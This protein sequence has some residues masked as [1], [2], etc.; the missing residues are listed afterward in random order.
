M[1]HFYKHIL[2]GI[3]FWLILSQSLSLFNSSSAAASSRAVEVAEEDDAELQ[4]NALQNEEEG[5]EGHYF[6]ELL[7][8]VKREIADVETGRSSSGIF[9]TTLAFT[10]PLFSFTLPDRAAAGKDYTKQAAWSLIGLAAIGGIAIFPYVWTARGS[11][12][13]DKNIL[14]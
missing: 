3:V 8:V 13:A 11:A 6:G 10:I 9:N 5:S 12:K 7:K 4:E 2:S 14:A 1:R